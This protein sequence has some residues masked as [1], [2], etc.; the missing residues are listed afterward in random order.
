M[1]SIISG[2]NSPIHEIEKYIAKNIQPTIE[3][4]GSYI[5]NAECFT[6]KISHTTIDQGDI[7]P[8]KIPSK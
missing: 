6:K 2:I 4:A 5:K 1:Q 7:L 3:K 8:M